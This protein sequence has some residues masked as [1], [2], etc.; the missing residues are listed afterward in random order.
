MTGPADLLAAFPGSFRMGGDSP[1]VLRVPS[2]RD[3][4]SELVADCVL[5]L[6]PGDARD[7]LEEWRSDSWDLFVAVH[8]H[9]ADLFELVAWAQAHPE[10]ILAVAYCAPPPP[11]A[12]LLERDRG[13][14]EA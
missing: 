5:E 4:V 12:F 14:S 7:F 2:T 10:V 1:D 3:E 13:D 11:A 9:H 6:A 8:P